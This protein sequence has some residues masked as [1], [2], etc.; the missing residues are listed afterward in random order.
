M[1]HYTTTGADRPSTCADIDRPD[2]C[3]AVVI[4]NSA[5]E[6]VAHA[7]S[8]AEACRWWAESGR[9]GDYIAETGELVS[10]VLVTIWPTASAQIDRNGCAV[11]TDLPD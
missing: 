10:R 11:V 9:R 3:A 6:T 1:T 7:S 2:V 4:R 8:D 5:G